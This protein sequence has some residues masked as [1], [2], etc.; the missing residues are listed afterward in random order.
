VGDK[1][2]YGTLIKGD[3]QGEL[4]TKISSFLIGVLVLK[5]N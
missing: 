2:Q 1:R 4:E 3:I 5:I